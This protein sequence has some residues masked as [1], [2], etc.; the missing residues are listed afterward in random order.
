MVALV[1]AR[2][3]FSRIFFIQS[4]WMGAYTVESPNKPCEKMA[5]IEVLLALFVGRFCRNI[6]I[7]PMLHKQGS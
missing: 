6:L 4:E 1:L 7:K 3:R 2:M 5:E